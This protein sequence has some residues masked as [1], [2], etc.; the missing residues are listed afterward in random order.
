MHKALFLSVVV[1]L[2]MSLPFHAGC[3]SKSR[4]V[5]SQP[6]PPQQYQEAPQ[7]QQT[8]PVMGGPVVSYQAPPTLPNG[9]PNLIHYWYEYGG[10]RPYWQGLIDPQQVKLLGPAWRDPAAHAQLTDTGFDKRGR[11]GYTRRKAAT[12]KPAKPICTVP[13]HAALPVQTG[14]AKAD[15]GKAETK[16][17]GTAKAA[18]A[19]PRLV[20][21]PKPTTYSEITP[22]AAVAGKTGA[23][24]VSAPVQAAPV[25]P[26]AGAM[27]IPAP[28]PLVPAA[29]QPA[30]T[31]AAGQATGGAVT[32]ISHQ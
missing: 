22:K 16:P 6:L 10:A 20:P 8:Q 1:A 2:G 19:S 25:V 28:A 27:P 30:P 7:A 18:S 12:A 29:P 17:Q 26:G 14:A 31:T 13:E 15:A 23:A 5:Q 11:K 32:K 3:V 21:G 24:P 4:R 9:N